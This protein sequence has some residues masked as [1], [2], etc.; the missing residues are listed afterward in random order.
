MEMGS[1]VGWG[2][3]KQFVEKLGKKPDSQAL[4]LSHCDLT[5]TDIVELGESCSKPTLGQLTVCVYANVFVYGFWQT[6]WS[7]VTYYKYIITNT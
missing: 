1:V 3:V 2:R 6:L 4:S 5:A 7:K